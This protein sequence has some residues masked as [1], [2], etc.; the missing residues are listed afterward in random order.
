VNATGY[1]PG[2]AVVRPGWQYSASA[3]KTQALTANPIGS[4]DAYAFSIGGL[5]IAVDPPM[6]DRSMAESFVADWENVIIGIR[7]D[8]KLEYFS[9]GVI[10]DPATGHVVLNL[11][12]QDVSALRATFRVGF[13]L[14]KPA[15]DY[16]AGLSPVAVVL[17]GD[18]SS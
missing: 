7:Q 1:R 15:T 10:S 5:P 8:V 11:L 12:Q 4:T 13:L 18:V 2:S 6:W 14:A 16:G 9:T 3:Q 17:P